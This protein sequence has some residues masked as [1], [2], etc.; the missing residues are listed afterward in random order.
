[1]N[2]ESL[3][4]AIEDIIQDTEYTEDMIV[5]MIN[6]AVLKV[7]TGDILPGKYQIS[8][9]L[10]DLYSTGDVLTVLGTGYL[11]LPADFN[12]DLFMVVDSNGDPVKIEESFKKFLVMYADQAAGSV[13]RCSVNGGRFHYRDIPAAATTLTVHYYTNPDTLVNDAD[14]PSSIPAILHR[15]LI[16]GYVCREIFNRIEDGIEGQKINTNYYATEYGTGLL[17][18]EKFVGIDGSADYYNDQTDYCA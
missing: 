16:V 14:V 18:L 8:P 2:L 3:V 13:F 5:T 6:E 15:K 11:S 10:P 7:A 9:P 4:A 12:R 17:D 1:M